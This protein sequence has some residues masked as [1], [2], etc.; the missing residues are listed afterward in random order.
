VTGSQ[1]QVMRSSVF[2][3]RVLSRIVRAAVA[4]GVLLPAGQAL[5][6]SGASATTPASAANPFAPD[7]TKR[8][9]VSKAV[10][11]DAGIIVNARNDGFIEVAAAGPEKTV[12]L[13]LRTLAAR[14]WVDSTSRMMR[15]RLRKSATPRS[16]RSDIQE[17][18]KNTT[19]AVTR[20]VTA[21]ESAY[22]LAFSDSPSTSFTI[23]IEESE[24]DV[25]V[26]IVR[27]VVVQS[28]KMLDKPDTTARADS[29]PPVPKKKKPAAKKPVTPKPVAPNPVAPKP[30]P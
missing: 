26:A 15:A 24:A 19:M 7:G 28:A 22:A 4:A 6:Q 8:V 3:Q 16:F 25:F 12:M 20:T 17:Y 27:K 14:A 2:R 30:T 1:N 23:P 18:G 5:A 29:A 11:G 13:Q 10:F 21:G 9:T